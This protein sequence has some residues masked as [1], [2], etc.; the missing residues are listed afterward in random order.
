M[1]A[2]HSDV[3]SGLSGLGP[4][5]GK[6][7]PGRLLAV[8]DEPRLLAS[9]RHLLQ[10]AGHQVTTANGGAAALELLRREEFDLVLLDL[11]MPGMD[12]REVM[13]EIANCATQPSIVVVSGNSDIDVAIDAMRNGA[14]DFIRKP[15]DADVLLRAIENTLAR[16]RLERENR[17]MQTRLQQSE[18]WHRFL[19]DHSPDLIYILDQDGRF[20]F[21]SES[22]QPLLG[23]TRAEL[24]G[25]HFDTILHPD[26]VERMHR[27]LAARLPGSNAG[28]HL[29][30]RLIPK[31]SVRGELYFESQCIDIDLNA[32][33]LTRPDVDSANIPFR[34][35]YGVAKDI[36][37]RKKAEEMIYHQAYHDLLTGLPN[38]LLFKDHLALAIAQAK[39]SGDR[40]AVMFLDLDRFK[41]V[42]DTLG[43]VIGDQLLQNVAARLA[44]CVREGD[45][46]A[47]FGGDEFTLLLPRV[48]DRDG[49]ENIARK[50]NAVLQRPFHLGG[51]EIHTGTSIGIAIYPDDGDQMDALIKNADIAMYAAKAN[52][53]D[54]FTFFSATRD[55]LYSRRL[56]L[57][58]EMRTGIQAGQF[59]VYYQPLVETETGRVVAV[60]A[61]ARWMHPERGLIMPDEF[62]PVAEESGLICSLGASLLRIACG[63]ALDW[64]DDNGAPLPLSVNLSACQIDQDDFVAMVTRTLDEV[65]FDPHRLILE[66]TETAMMRNLDRNKEKLRTISALGVR[67]AIDDFGTGYSSLG[68]LR[69]LPI[70]TIKIDRSFVNDVTDLPAHAA[71]VRALILIARG[72]GL[73][74][75]A[76]G[77]ESNAQLAFLRENECGRCQG[78]L[79]GQPAPAAEI[80]RRL[81]PQSPAPTP[82]SQVA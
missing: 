13:R 68:Y 66:I 41:R 20:A 73:G 36:T 75:V 24:L 10:F 52:G 29:E 71:I 23:Y 79:F 44:A 57:E 33:G 42:N 5:I 49:V 43:H 70:D 54:G 40:L 17:A 67:I 61:L 53:R 64:R 39:R 46:L 2:I 62:I 47:R 50:L 9:L 3:S 8:D 78:F 31:E 45:T 56:G 74:L 12:G 65:G 60:E 37:E 63:E 22:V 25:R 82:S 26:D 55:G 32:F 6:E 28:S 76:E 35:T 19:V 16:R 58:A 80:V 14:S 21:L 38:R 72:L 18:L 15:Y 48:T 1:S 34:G 27:V 81:T 11:R 69:Q 30:L 4:H 77:V 59:V 7:P 51:Q